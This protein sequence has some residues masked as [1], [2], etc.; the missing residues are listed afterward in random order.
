M[1]YISING[2]EYYYQDEGKKGDTLLFCYS[3]LFNQ[4]MFDQQVDDRN[5]NYRCIRFD[6]RGHG[7][8]A[9]PE[10]GYSLDELTQDV[11]KLLYDLK[12]G[13]CHII[14][15]SMGGMVALRLAIK[16][17]DLLKSLVLIDTSSE[18]EPK[19]DQIRNMAMLFIAKHIGLKPLAKKV[20][21]LFFGEAFLK[22]PNRN[23][24]R[25][26]W[27]NH[28]LANDRQG[29]VKAVKGVLYRQGVT[30]KIGGV[31]HPTTILVGE[32]DHLTDLEKA[33]ILKSNIKQ[34]SLKVIPR[35]GH[36]D[37]LFP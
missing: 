35:A 10:H 11:V 3:M 25:T 19:K 9:S 23:E 7:R 5:Y 21:H 33:E 37:N 34:A 29:I 36:C 12:C 26:I 8:S 32:H 1:P 14:G 27:K 24:I 18:P 16:Y 31:K 2:T 17:P 6:F 30:E 28:F 4:H 20:M 13:P 15:F 22:D